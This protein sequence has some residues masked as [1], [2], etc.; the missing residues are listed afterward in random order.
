MVATPAKD[1]LRLRSL[2]MTVT[3]QFTDVVRP[4]S[5]IAV[6]VNLVLAAATNITQFFAEG[7]INGTMGGESF[8]D[9]V[10]LTP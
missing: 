5:P 4:S 6:K 8:N 1:Y 9:V 10:F 3:G 7:A 2:R